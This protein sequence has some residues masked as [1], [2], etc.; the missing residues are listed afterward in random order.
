MY[1]AHHRAQ[2][3]LIHRGVIYPIPKERDDPPQE[4]YE[5]IDQLKEQL[6]HI[7]TGTTDTGTNVSG[8]VAW[9]VVAR[10]QVSCRVGCTIHAV[11]VSSVHRLVVIGAIHV[12]DT[13]ASEHAASTARSRASRVVTPRRG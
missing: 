10:Y 2:Q 7:N 13:I 3:S 5:P 12:S 1:F 9:Y 4:K 11:T 6:A 8:G